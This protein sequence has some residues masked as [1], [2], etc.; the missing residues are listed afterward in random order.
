MLC[1]LAV[2]LFVTPHQAWADSSASDDFGRADG[3]LGPDWTATSDGG[4]VISSQAAVGGSA[5]VTG[6]MWAGDSFGSDQFSQVTLTGTQLTGAQWIG[7][8]VRMQ[9]S[10]QDAYRGLGWHCLSLPLCIRARQ[11]GVL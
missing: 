2:P 11:P 3:T 6:D 10:G 5:G 9:A 8:A 7:P 4:L 1:A